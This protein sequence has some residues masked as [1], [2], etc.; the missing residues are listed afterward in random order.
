MV[1][2]S[3]FLP[4]PTYFTV[5]EEFS[6]LKALQT[7]SPGGLNAALAT[8]LGGLSHTPWAKSMRE[9][10]SS[11]NELDQLA[12]ALPCHSEERNNRD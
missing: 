10:A 5:G 12:E 8:I 11:A 2:E 1:A 9:K 4:Q 6:H 7:S 3:Q